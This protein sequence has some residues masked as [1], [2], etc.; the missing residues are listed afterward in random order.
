MEMV[1][2]INVLDLKQ[3]MLDKSLVVIDVRTEEE[4]QEYHIEGTIHIP[5][6]E[7]PSKIYTFSKNDELYFHCKSGK[8]SC[9]ACTAFS[10]AGFRN[11]WN[12]KGG[13]LAWQNANL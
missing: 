8:R 13:I 2:E 5:L 7:L 11:I 10:Q 1:N 12:V 4:R 3:K 9:M 6:D